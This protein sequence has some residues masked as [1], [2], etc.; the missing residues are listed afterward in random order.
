MTLKLHDTYC[1]RGTLIEI[2]DEMAA[3]I[4]ADG[5]N[6]HQT[7][8]IG[9]LAGGAPIA[10][11]LAD[12]LEIHWGMRPPVGYVD[13]HLYR[14]DMVDTESEPFV[15]TGEIPFS[16]QNRNLILVDDV[17]FTGRTAR[18]ALAAILD[19]GR[20]R[21]IRLAVVVDRGF[22]ELPIAP[23]YVGCTIA[24]RREQA[25]RVRTKQ[26]GQEESGIYIYEQT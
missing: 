5:A 24:T 4:A 25:V 13:I 11:Y 19:K 23:D 12:R 3:K 15:R 21:M 6:P 18:A 22:R 16:I 14:D 7:A 20:P 10:R 17:I 26:D 9:V 1:N 8:L 2:L